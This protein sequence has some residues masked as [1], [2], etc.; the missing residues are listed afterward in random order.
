MDASPKKN[1]KQRILDA[2]LQLFN[3]RSFGAVSL[4]DIAHSLNMSRGNLAYHFPD[5]KKVLQAISGQMW[6]KIHQDRAK[7]R[8]YPSFQNLDREARFYRQYQKEYSFI[9]LD[10]HVSNLPEI[11]KEFQE[12]TEMTIQDNR[13]VIA[14]AIKIGN[15]KPEPFPGIYDHIAFVTWSL[16]FYALSQESMRGGQ[17]L[18]ETD[19]AIWAMILPHFTPKGIHAFTKFYGED[20]LNNLGNPFSFEI[21]EFISF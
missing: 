17:A 9:F 20:Y 19:K 18:V 10:P 5:K 4:Q 12:M 7:A 21:E 11:Q 15:M 6:S 2:A 3:E 1:T 14:F 16:I 8:R 13:A